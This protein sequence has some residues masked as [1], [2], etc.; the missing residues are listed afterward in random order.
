MPAYPSTSLLCI[1]IICLHNVTCGQMMPHL[2]CQVSGNELGFVK[3]SLYWGVVIVMNF[4]APIYVRHTPLTTPNEL[5]L[6]LSLL[7]N[8]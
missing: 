2:Q 8:A 5:N 1:K 6:K 3:F 4:K 7:L